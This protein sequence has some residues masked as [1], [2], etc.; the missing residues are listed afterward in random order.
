MATV[1]EE[2]PPAPQP[3]A[4]AEPGPPEQAATATPEPVAPKPPAPAAQGSAQ[5]AAVPTRPQQPS[6]EA[7]AVAPAAP[8]VPPVMPAPVQPVEAASETPAET[9]PARQDETP[10]EPVPETGVEPVPETGNAETPAAADLAAAP[11]PTGEVATAE[12]SLPAEEETVHV[13]RTY[14]LANSDARIVITAMEDSWIEVTDAEGA[15]LLSRTL[16][17]GDRYRVPDRE[18]LLL[19]T[20]NAGGL[21]IKV[22][23]DSAPRLGDV[24]IVR[25]NVKLDPVL[26]SEGRAWP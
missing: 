23:G 2:T 3:E 10:V 12:P 16:R 22:D 5:I 18:G 14:G 9:L 26:L 13:P 24:G 1:V 7:T 15:R 20:G 19:V 4:A 6:V 17:A 11:P 8:E 21:D 25:K